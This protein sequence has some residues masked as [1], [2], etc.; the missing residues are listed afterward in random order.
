MCGYIFSYN[1]YLSNDDKKEQGYKAL[2]LINHRGP[3]QANLVVSEDTLIGH[4]RLSIID[5]HGRAVKSGL[6]AQNQTIDVSFLEN[7][8][9]IIQLIHEHSRYVG[10]YI[11]H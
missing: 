8:M 11:K 10:T 5:I 1:K 4:C 9:Y 6:V 7:G 3:D 2:N